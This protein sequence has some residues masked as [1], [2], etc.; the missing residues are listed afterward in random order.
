MPYVNS[1]AISRIEYDDTTARMSVTFHDSGP[2][3]FCNVPLAVYE[4][5]L[6]AGSKG[7]YYNDHI[8]DRYPC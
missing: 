7:G 3:T 5:F 1:T 2:Y 6:S 4:E 8:K